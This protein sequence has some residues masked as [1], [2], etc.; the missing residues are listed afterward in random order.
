MVK[1]K[2]EHKHK[3][4]GEIR[5]NKIMLVGDN[6]ERGIYSRFEALKM[7]DDLNLDLV[8]MS[9]N[10]EGVGICKLMDYQKYLYRQKKNKKQADK[11]VTKEIRFKPFIETADFERKTQQTIKFLKKGYK[12]K[13][14]CLFVGR[15]WENKRDRILELTYTLL[16]DVVEF[17]IPEQMPKVR[18]KKMVCIIRP[19]K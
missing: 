9:I 7:A 6:V 2:K 11:V 13:L 16:N 3:I 18:D 15:G 17:G 8:Q 4:N 1:N 12:V 19:K 14:D 5:T 10:K